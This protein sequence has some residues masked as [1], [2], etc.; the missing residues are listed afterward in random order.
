MTTGRGR[1]G[2]PWPM[3]RRAAS[4]AAPLCPDDKINRRFNAERC[5]RRRVPVVTDVPT[6]SATA[7]VALVVDLVAR[8][9]LGG[10]VSRSASAPVVG[11]ALG[12]RDRA[13]P[14]GPATDAGHRGHCGWQRRAVIGNPRRAVRPWWVDPTCC[15]SAI[16]RR[17]A[18]P[19]TWLR[20][21][22]PRSGPSVDQATKAGSRRRSPP[23][24]W[25]CVPSSKR[26]GRRPMHRSARTMAPQ[27]RQPSAHLKRSRGPS[28]GWTPAT[29]RRNSEI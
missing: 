2:R 10:H 21:D 27:H 6:W 9:V 15:D 23:P 24:C 7:G 28:L 18:R 20:G 4:A 26:R 13:E 16:D 17:G 25:R 3:D 5:E 11:D 29:L 19:M 22:R 1:T 12:P 14:E 8:R